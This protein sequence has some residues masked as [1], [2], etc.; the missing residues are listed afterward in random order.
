MLSATMSSSLR[1]QLTLSNSRKNASDNAPSHDQIARGRVSTQH[2]G[3]SGAVAVKAKRG[4]TP[5]QRFYKMSAIRL[6]GIKS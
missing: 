6:N 3:D 2:L 1:P 4:I 5:N